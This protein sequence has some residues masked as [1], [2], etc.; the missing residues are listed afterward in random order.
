MEALDESGTLV[1]QV[2]VRL[3]VTA[4]QGD[5]S[6]TQLIEVVNG[7]GMTVTLSMDSVDLLLSGDLPTLREIEADPSLVRVIIDAATL[8]VGQ[9][10]NVVP[11]I[12]LPEGITYQLVNSFVVVT[13]EEP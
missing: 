2:A 8:S 4:L 12:I 11:E 7:E 1:Q 13:K 6:L 9:S 5:L 3:Q 10:E